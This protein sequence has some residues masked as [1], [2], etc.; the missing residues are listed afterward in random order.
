MRTLSYTTY[1][2]LVF[3][4]DLAAFETY[5]NGAFARKYNLPALLHEKS[6]LVIGCKSSKINCKSME[7]GMENLMER[8]EKELEEEKREREKCYRWRKRFKLL[9][10]F[11]AIMASISVVTTTFTMS[12]TAGF[13]VLGLVCMLSYPLY[14]LY[15][16]C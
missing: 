4:G 16:E 15:N 7:N 2:N 12:L 3:I 8:L 14:Q 9:M 11:G 10:V 6:E 5:I 13:I 1:T